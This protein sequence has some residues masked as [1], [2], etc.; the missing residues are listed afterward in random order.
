[1]DVEKAKETNVSD[2]S[3]EGARALVGAVVGAA[4]VV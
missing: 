3:P 4:F 2:E 1:M